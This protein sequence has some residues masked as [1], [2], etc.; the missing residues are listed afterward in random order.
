MSCGRFV[1][2]LAELKITGLCDECSNL[3]WKALQKFLDL[4]P[5]PLLELID[6]ALK[7]ESIDLI[8][9]PLRYR[10][11]KPSEPTKDKEDLTLKVH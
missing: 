2:R 4:Q 8:S 3:G 5:A 9:N 1:Q 10:G 6:A 7:K 11:W